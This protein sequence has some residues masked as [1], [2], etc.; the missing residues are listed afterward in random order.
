MENTNSLRDNEP[1]IFDNFLG[2]KVDGSSITYKT[3][4]DPKKVEEF[5]TGAHRS[6]STDKGRY[7]LIPGEATRRLAIKY[8]QGANAYGERNWEK[9]MKFSRLISSAKR[10]IDQYVEGKRNED[11]LAAAAWNLF[12]AMHFELWK[13]ELND[14]PKRD[15]PPTQEVVQSPG[16]NIDP[17]FLQPHW[18]LAQGTG[19]ATQDP[20]MKILA[21]Y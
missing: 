5:E 14:L 17:G 9:G 10:H 3:D 8:E 1:Q 16:N 21:R 18:G 4:Y 11:H 13:P 19:T 6:S 20:K 7:D 15:N 2:K 12:A